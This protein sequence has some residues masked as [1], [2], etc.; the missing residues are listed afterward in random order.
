[1]PNFVVNVGDKQI[2]MPKLDI[3]RVVQ[4]EDRKTFLGNLNTQTNNS[5]Q[6]DTILDTHKDMKDIVASQTSGG[7]FLNETG[8]KQVQSD[9]H[10]ESLKSKQQKES[11]S[12]ANML[13]YLNKCDEAIS[14]IFDEAPFDGKD[15]ILVCS[16]FNQK[17]KIKNNNLLDSLR[18]EILKEDEER[19]SKVYEDESVPKSL[20]SPTT[21]S[22]PF[23]LRD[24]IKSKLTDSNKEMRASA[25][26]YMGKMSLSSQLGRQIRQ[27]CASV[28]EKEE[29]QINQLR[30]I[31]KT[32]MTMSQ[33]EF[34]KKSQMMC[35][36]ELDTGSNHLHH[37]SQ[38]NEVTRTGKIQMSTKIIEDVQQRH[39]A[40]SEN[41]ALERNQNGSSDNCGKLFSPHSLTNGTDSMIGS[42]QA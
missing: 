16:N 1:M 17:E 3:Q 24:S 13:E 41:Q 42:L 21:F 32:D 34:D 20:K 2:K 6:T 12:D 35:L 7:S 40:P 14:T 30:S 29:S 8:S 9:C 22:M 39:R 31:T 33:K 27:S 5:L 26:T 36:S 37:S 11:E 23:E 38:K 25:V 19:L 10:Q 4:L 15:N 18:E 28:E